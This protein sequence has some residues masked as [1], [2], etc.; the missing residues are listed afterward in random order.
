[1]IRT[2]KT[3]HAVRFVGIAVLLIWSI[4]P[5]YWALVSSFMRPV[6]M[7]A[8]PPNYWPPVFTLEH[9]RNLLGAVSTFQGQAISSVW[10]QFSKAVINSVLVSTAATLVTTA[11]AAFGGYAFARISFAGRDAIFMAV[12]ATLAIPAYTVMIPL[13]RMMVSAG[14]VDTYLGVTLVHTTT[15]FPL[16]LWLMRGTYK[17]LPISLEEAAALDG[18][19]RLYTLCFIV[20]PLAAPGIVAAAI[21]TFLGA[22]GQFIVPLVFSPTLSTKP[23]T[24]LITEFVAKNYVDYGLMNAAGILTS[25]PPLLVVIFLNRFLVRGLAAGANK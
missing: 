8:V 17:A 19:G 14:L 21:L 6:D 3:T 4:G 24:V 22:W 2:S 9:Y 25:I 18:A 15:F 20:M 13:Y 1:M 11:L 5:I 16:A 23:L 7:T 10:P 12:I